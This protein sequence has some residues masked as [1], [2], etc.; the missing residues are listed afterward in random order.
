LSYHVFIERAQDPA[1]VGAVAAAIAE[2]YGLPSEAIAR[3]MSTGRFRVKANVDLDT[4]KAFARD[5]ERLGAICT[6]ADAAGGQSPTAPPRQSPVGTPP[7]AAAAPRRPPAIPSGPARARNPA[8]VAKAATVAAPAPTAP[9]PPAPAAPDQ[10]ESG[11]SAAFGPSGGAR[12]SQELGAIDTGEFKLSSIDGVDG[13]AGVFAEQAQVTP[14][15]GDGAFAPPTSE[16]KQLKLETD[17]GSER[18][19]ATPIPDASELPE[20]SDMFAPPEAEEEALQLLET[21]PVQ[22]RKTPP[23]MSAAAPPEHM[24]EADAAG[25]SFG[26]STG[27]AEAQAEGAVRAKPKTDVR[28]LF[29]ERVVQKPR[30]RLAAGVVLCLFLAWIPAKIFWGAKVDNAQAELNLS[31]QEPASLAKTDENAWKDLDDIGRAQKSL[32]ES[33]LVNTKI[34]AVLIWVAFGGV[35]GFLYFKKIPWDDI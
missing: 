34:S 5:L 14:P 26:D 13:D 17:P 4:A 30:V 11:L 20:V 6:V 28:A 3:R 27:A 29:R 33:R 1:N 21:E 24:S 8:A 32:A 7:P 31:M 9:A 16:E 15:P 2:R 25:A 12:P 22:P 10:Y 18:L 19:E 35:L 23:P